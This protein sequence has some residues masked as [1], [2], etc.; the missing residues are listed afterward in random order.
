M[1][2]TKHHCKKNKNINT[3]TNTKQNNTKKQNTKHNKKTQHNTTKKN[4]GMTGAHHGACGDWH[5]FLL[6]V[7]YVSWRALHRRDARSGRVQE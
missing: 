7:R 5:C 4:V 2:I 3:N 6:L 1:Y